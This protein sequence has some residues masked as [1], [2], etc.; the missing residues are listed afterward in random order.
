VGWIGILSLA[1]FLSLQDA[2][3]RHRWQ[4]AVDFVPLHYPDFLAGGI[5]IGWVLA[6]LL[7]AG[8]S[9][10]KKRESN[11]APAAF[12][13]IAV[14]AWALAEQ[15]GNP[16]VPSL[17]LN[18]FLIVLGIFTLLRGIR[19][20]R[21]FEANF[22]MLVIAVLAIARFFDTDLEFVVRGIAFIAIGLGFLMTNLI[23]F[24]R[25]ART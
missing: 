7:F 1:V 18:F 4:L 20:D 13:P 9:L 12:T 21:A 6:A 24:K 19:G 2:W 14:I 23:V 10:W 5:Q 15:T 3:Q 16:V 22:G 17:L 25:R 8:F 11:L